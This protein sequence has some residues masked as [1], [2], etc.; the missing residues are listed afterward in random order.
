MTMQDADLIAAYESGRSGKEIAKE[1]GKPLTYIIRR[2]RA[3]GVSLRTPAEAARVRKAQIPFDL[4]QVMGLRR[5]GMTYIQIAAQF[6]CHPWTVNKRLRE[7]GINEFIP[8][9]HPPLDTLQAFR[10]RAEGATYIQIA[11]Q[12]DCT[13][14]GLRRALQEAGMRGFIRKG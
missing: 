12:L 1:S 2:L 10:L 5:Q 14:N 3:S 8:K 9:R 4:M 13:V 6:G 11:A 7:A